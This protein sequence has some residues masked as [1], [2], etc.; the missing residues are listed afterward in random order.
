MWD[1]QKMI[2]QAGI[3]GSGALLLADPQTG[4]P[5]IVVPESKKEAEALRKK[6]SPTGDVPAQANPKAFVSNQAPV[7][8]DMLAGDIKGWNQEMVKKLL[9]EERS[10]IEQQA[11]AL[12]NFKQMPQGIDWK[13][14]AAFL[15]TAVKGGGK[16]AESMP[17]ADTPEQRAMKIQ[18][19]ENLLQNQRGDLTKNVTKFVNDRQE[20]F[21]KAQDLKKEDT[22]RNDISKSVI[23][24]SIE[25]HKNLGIMDTA[26]ASGDSQKILNTLSTYARSIS[27]EKGVLTDNDIV[28]V[29]PANYQGTVA[30]VLAY[31]S[32][33]PNAKL[34]PE[35]TQSMRE[36][37]SAAR[38]QLAQK[39]ADTL[40]A[41]KKMYSNPQSSY[42]TLTGAGN[43][44][45]AIFQEGHAAVKGLMGATPSLATNAGGGLPSAADI[46]AE[47]AR[48]AGKK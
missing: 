47:L 19:L 20:R 33:T 24:P 41:K 45:D 26:L 6:L 3:P 15:D 36:M 35:Y 39:Y 42:R 28:R 46:E 25:D 44:G 11:Q 48:R 14:M 1:M 17:T 34:P 2:E 5:G 23:Q 9:L 32:A 31:F 37:V 38:A 7:S 29:M 18:Q 16:L 10:G 12:Q 27:G 8:Q 30:R 21:Q 13:P 22:L 40:E 43:V 4:Q